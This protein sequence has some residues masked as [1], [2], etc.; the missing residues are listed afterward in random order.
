MIGKV[1]IVAAM[2]FGLM[3][4]AAFASEPSPPD[5]QKARLICRGAARELGSHIV[6]PRRCRTAEQWRVDD[7]V[8]A[9]A[10]NNLRL[11][12][13]QHDGHAPRAPQ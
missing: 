12:E 13:G 6:R 7:E 3:L 4:T 11:T 9:Q 10:A 5:A 2:G 1:G 8:S